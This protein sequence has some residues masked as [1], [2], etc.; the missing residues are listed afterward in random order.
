MLHNS[1][2]LNKKIKVTAFRVHV[3]ALPIYESW[4]RSCEVDYLKW[5]RRQCPCVPLL[6]LSICGAKCLD[7]DKQSTFQGD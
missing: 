4:L 6:G 3:D 2:G 1:L 5:S 7:A